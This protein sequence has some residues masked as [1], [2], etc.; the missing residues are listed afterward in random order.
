[1]SGLAA[2]WEALWFSE[3]DGRPLAAFRIGFGVFV[4]A[5]LARFAADITLRFS[6]QGV[7]TAHALGWVPSSNIAHLLFGLSLASTVAFTVGYRVRWTTPLSALGFLHHWAVGLSVRFSAFDHLILLL[8]LVLCF[9]ESDARWALGSKPKARVV[10]W[11][12]RLLL[13]QLFAL[14]VGAALWKLQTEAWF[15]GELLRHT[16][17]GMWATPAAFW[18]AGQELPLAVWDALTAATIVLELLLVPGLLMR[19]T[20]RV[21]VFAGTFFHLAMAV[22]LSVPEFMVCV[23]VYVLLW[24]PERAPSR[25]PSRE[26]GT[27]LAP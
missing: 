10:A 13:L 8:W 11:P 2:R 19:R 5:Y 21:A 3:V 26:V 16:I 18:V 27:P 23:I 1:M 17:M 14:Y 20:R 7:T 12:Q 6:S 22:L 24:E 4:F 9:A 25:A 15:T